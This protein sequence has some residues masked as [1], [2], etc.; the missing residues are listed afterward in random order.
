MVTTFIPATP[1]DVPFIRALAERSWNA[2]YPGIISQD[3][4][5]YMLDWMYSEQRLTH[6]IETR[7]CDYVLFRRENE[8]VGFAAYGPGEE[9]LEL[10][11]H[12][13]YLLPELFGTGL[14]TE[15]LKLLVEEAE[16]M[17]AYQIS[18]RV[19]R[20]NERA[21]RCYRRNGFE[22]SHEVTSEIGNGFVMD[23]Y[24][25]VKTLLE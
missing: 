8:T 3:Q 20:Q 16:D 5:A 25:M 1:G 23:D 14:G 10:H 6:E 15:A 11:L 13:F 22:I 24:W 12:K 7:R 4:I 9:D 19:N 2:A 21:I 18:L 17:G